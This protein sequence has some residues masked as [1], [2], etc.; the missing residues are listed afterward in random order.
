M[1]RVSCVGSVARSPRLLVATSAGALY[2]YAL[3][4]AEGGDCAL[5]RTHALLE[6]RAAEPPE[7]TAPPPRPHS[8]PAP[9][10]TH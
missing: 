1:C 8:P 4:A 5:L 6:P 9:P 2:V 7:G 3:D 10:A